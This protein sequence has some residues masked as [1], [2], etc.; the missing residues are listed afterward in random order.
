MIG[1]SHISINDMIQTLQISPEI[2]KL[3]T[4]VTTLEKELGKVIIEEIK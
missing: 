2:V 1:C 4:E 3:Q